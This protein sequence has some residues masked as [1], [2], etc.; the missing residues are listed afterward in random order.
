MADETPKSRSSTSKG[1][2]ELSE[3][4]M[5]GEFRLVRRLGVGGMAEVWLAEQT[6]LHRMVA[7]KMLKADALTDETLVKRFEVEAKAVATLNHPN[8]VQI[9]TVGRHKGTQFIAQEYVDGNS[10]REILRKKGPL[11]LQRGIHVMRQVAGA[12]QAAGERGIVHRDI[13][14]ENIM[15]SKKGEVKVAD[16]GLAQLSEGGEKLH[17]TSEGMTLGTPHYMSPEQVQGDKLDPRSDIYS[18]GVTCYHML[19]GETPFKGDTAVSVAVQHLNTEPPSLRDLRPDLPEGLCAMV[20]RMMAKS[21]KD[22]YPNAQAISNELRGLAKSVKEGDAPTTAPAPSGKPGSKATP[23]KAGAG[24]PAAAKTR[25]AKPAGPL[26]WYQKPKLAFS[27][28]AIFAVL[29][30][31]GLGFALHPGDPAII[32]PAPTL[33]AKM[34]TAESQFLKAMMAVDNEEAFLAVETY[35]PDDKV[36][37]LRAHEQLALYYLA[38][39]NRWADAERLLNDMSQVVNHP[40]HANKGRVGLAALALGRGDTS[41]ARSLNSSRGPELEQSLKDSDSWR[42]K[43]KETVDGLNPGNG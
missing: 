28:V 40:T 23:A 34:E 10:L 32:P 19:S 31:A 29:S 2:E 24:K 27:L 4:M 39:N 18:F 1:S 25:P 11:D 42:R 30:G 7:I 13:K 14:P 15:I 26:R 21:L 17:L 38:R 36:Y 20:A 37:V 12:L 5:L 8:I 33:P 6:S 3:N 43:W 16:F 41:V 9:Y 22:R 35:F